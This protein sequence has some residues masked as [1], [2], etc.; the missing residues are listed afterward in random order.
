MA[1]KKER[2]RA[3]GIGLLIVG[4]LFIGINWYT[5]SYE[6]FWLPKLLITGIVVTPMGL[7]LTLVPGPRV[8]MDDSVKFFGLKWRAASWL[9]RII[10]ILSILI[11]GVLAIWVINYYDLPLI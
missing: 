8:S 6:Y 9:E 11:G 10:W 1:P 7:A 4:I 5:I 3:L 2:N